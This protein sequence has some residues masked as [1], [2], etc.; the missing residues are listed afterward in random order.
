[1]SALIF[2][3]GRAYILYWG[4]GLNGHALQYQQRFFHVFESGR[5]IKDCTSAANVHPILV[6]FGQKVISTRSSAFLVLN[7][8]K[9][10]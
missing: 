5:E 4:K 7:W 2:A 1:M 10:I 6:K 9:H 3:L 8:A